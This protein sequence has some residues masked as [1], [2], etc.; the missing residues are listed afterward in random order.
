M[1]VH[2]VITTRLY[3]ANSLQYG[4]NIDKPNNLYQAR[5][6]YCIMMIAL[7][8][9]YQDRKKKLLPDAINLYLAC[10][11]LVCLLITACTGIDGTV[12]K[13]IIRAMLR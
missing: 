4:N 12:Y 13:I 2:H 3:T 5:Y 7:T 1:M 10:Y 6:E 9:L 11:H 8:T